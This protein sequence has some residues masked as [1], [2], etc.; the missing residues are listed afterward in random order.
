MKI[1]LLIFLIGGKEQSRYDIFRK[2][3][4]EIEDEDKKKGCLDKLE[5]YQLFRGDTKTAGVR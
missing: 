2:Y 4:N 1:L 5:I 3:V